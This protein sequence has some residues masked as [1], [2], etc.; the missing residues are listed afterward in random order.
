MGSERAVQLR[1]SPDTRHRHRHRAQGLGGLAAEICAARTIAAA[2]ACSAILKHD[3]VEITPNCE[4]LQTYG[5]MLHSLSRSSPRKATSA[6]IC[7][8]GEGPS[9]PS[10]VSLLPPCLSG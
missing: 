5:E 9:D 7:V 8:T 1:Q 4:L 10:Y 6:A 2:H 3:S